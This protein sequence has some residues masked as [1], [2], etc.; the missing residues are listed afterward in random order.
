MTAT[1]APTLPASAGG[2]D[3][4]E[5]PFRFLLDGEEV[6]TVSFRDVSKQLNIGIYVCTNVFEADWI[7]LVPGS[8]TGTS[9]VRDAEVRLSVATE[10]FAAQRIELTG[11]FAQ[12]GAVNR[13]EKSLSLQWRVIAPNGMA[14]DWTDCGR[15]QSTYT[16]ADTQPDLAGTIARVTGTANLQAPTGATVEARILCLKGNN[17]G[18]E[19]PLGFH[20]FTVRVWGRSGKFW[21][22]VR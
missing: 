6:D 1:L 14:G 22:V 20:D 10:T 8:P 3:A 17:S 12:L 2:L 7:A 5:T 9:D 16:T 18:R 15:F 4:S 11:I 19:A 13:M 21:I